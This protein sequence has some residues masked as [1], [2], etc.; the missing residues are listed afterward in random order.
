[1]MRY[2][3]INRRL[4]FMCEHGNESHIKEKRLNDT[5]VKFEQKKCRLC[6]F[7]QPQIDTRLYIKEAYE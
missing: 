2:D 7:L 5:Y 6:N 1:M 4:V 3:E